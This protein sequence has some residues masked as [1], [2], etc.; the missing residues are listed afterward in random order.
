[1]PIPKP[2]PGEAEGAY[3]DRCITAIGDEYDDNEEAIA[4][5]YDMWSNRGKGTSKMLKKRDNPISQCGLKFDGSK[6]GEFSGY[7]SVFGGVDSYGD[8]ILPGAYQD[9]IN[10]A[11]PKMFFNH[12]SWEIPVGDWVE[13]KEDDTGL[14]VV[15]QIDLNHKD[16]PSLYSALKRKAVDG[17]SIGYR[18][19]PGGATENDHG[20]YDLAKIDLKE[21]SAV[22]YPADSS[23]RISGVKHE[24]SAI[25]N[26][27]EAE[28]FLRDAGFSKSAAIALISRVKTLDS[29]RDADPAIKDEINAI[30]AKLQIQEVVSA[31]DN[32]KF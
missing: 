30:T 23:A 20:G 3:M 28:Q 2:K 14:F 5:C 11:T 8:T 29:R 27:R 18:I 7:A 17:L 1:M 9:S 25:N 24:I 31:I 13:L 15:G 22:N 26:I 21:I 12:D 16:G 4:V 32:F 6:Q 10:K 19:P